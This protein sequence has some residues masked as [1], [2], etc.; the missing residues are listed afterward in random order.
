MPRWSWFSTTAT[1]NW[2]GNSTMANADNSVVTTQTAGSGGVWMTAAILGL[3]CAASVRATIPP[4]N[5]QT[6]KTPT[7]RNATS[8]TIN[9]T[10]MARMRPC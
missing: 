1:W 2:R 8:L 10:A 9:S 5:L 4:F 3:D 6:T 7:A